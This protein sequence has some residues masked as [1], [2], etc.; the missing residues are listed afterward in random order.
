MTGITARTHALIPI[1]SIIV[2]G[3]FNN[4]WAIN[5]SILGH[6]VGSIGVYESGSS[7]LGL[8]SAG[9]PNT[10]TVSIY[11]VGWA[12]ANGSS[13]SLFYDECSEAIEE[14]QLEKFGDGFLYNTVVP[15]NQISQMDLFSPDF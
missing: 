2:R 4:N 10:I 11:R 6:R 5:K 14:V 15:Q 3:F 13:F 1:N 9:E 12:A 7:E 8:W